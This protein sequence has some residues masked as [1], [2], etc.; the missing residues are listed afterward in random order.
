ML[1]LKNPF[2]HHFRTQKASFRFLLCIFSNCSCSFLSDL[3][4]K[5]GQETVSS[6]VLFSFQLKPQP[7]EVR[8]TIVSPSSV[9]AF[10]VG[11][12]ASFSGRRTVFL[13]RFRRNA[14]FGYVRSS[15]AFSL[16][17]LARCVNAHVVVAA[18][19]QT[20]LRRAVAVNLHFAL[21]NRILH[22][23]RNIIAVGDLNADP[24]VL[25]AADIEVQL[26][27]ADVLRIDAR[28]LGRRCI[29]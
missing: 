11:S 16:P 22:Q 13:D 4:I 12:C 2:F 26:K 7:R 3:L 15:S 8:V 14:F 29:S 24:A 28:R 5:K 18:I 6:P 20:V 19:G 1:F 25:L 27:L 23:R 10:D 17:G 21:R 9:T